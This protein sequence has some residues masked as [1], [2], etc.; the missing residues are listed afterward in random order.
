MKTYEDIRNELKTGDI[1][2]FSGQGFI[3]DAIKWITKNEYSHV[4][5]VLR[6][7]G[8][9]YVALWESTT[10]GNVPSIFGGKRKG[11]QIVQLSQRLK[12]YRG[13]VV[14]RHLE[15]FE[16]GQKERAIIRRLRTEV[17]KKPYEKNIWSLIKSALDKT[18]LGRNRK[19]DLSSLFCSEL[20]AEAYTRLGLL[21]KNE[22]SS[23]Y[24]PAD[25]SA[26]AGMK[27]KGGA[28]LGPEIEI[29]LNKKDI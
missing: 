4:G 18:P 15:N 7:K 19:K 29:I 16:F 5:M 9:D 24:T 6:I 12:K 23:E 1:L 27:L 14:V 17:D 13:K 28:K 22:V 8:Y 26:K 21:P 25:F 20:V 2:L 11:V 10:L 3:S